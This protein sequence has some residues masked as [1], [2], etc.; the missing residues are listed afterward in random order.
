MAP[1]IPVTITAATVMETMPPCCW[2]ISI[3][4]GVVTLFGIREAVS[5]S[6]S[7]NNLHNPNTLM[8]E[9]REPTSVPAAI[10]RRFFLSTSI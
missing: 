2:E 7:P 8:M 3:A 9:V 4:I 6:L 1:K 10:G 5:S